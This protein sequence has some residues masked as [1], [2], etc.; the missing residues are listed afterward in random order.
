MT[1]AGNGKTRSA[2]R[3]RR[4]VL[5]TGIC[6]GTV[7]VVLAAV[8]VRLAGR[9]VDGTEG[10]IAQQNMLLAVFQG[11][12]GF[13]V[14]LS[15]IYYATLTADMAESMHSGLVADRTREV[16]A[17]VG[18]LVASA[19]GAA[20]NAGALAGLMRRSWR[21]YLPGARRPREQFL[22]STMSQMTSQL[23]SAL[24]WSEEVTHLD[25]NLRDPADDVVNAAVA[26]HDAGVAGS[27]DG[28]RDATEHLRATTDSLRKAALRTLDNLG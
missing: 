7:L 17:A 27:P 3:R 19:L 24:R 14:A 22:M 28:T 13:A 2:R 23:T 10:L 12:L 6:L 8:G 21:W 20:V 1:L 4:L 18:N 11:F 16:D 5:A 26:A 9:P 15:T 25:V